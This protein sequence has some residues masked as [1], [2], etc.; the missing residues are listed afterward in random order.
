MLEIGV[1][2]GG[3]SRLFADWLGDDAKIT[4]I[5]IDEACRNSAA[6]DRI[7]IEIG[8]Q[9]DR[10]FLSSLAEKHGPWDII[11]DDGGHT[12]NQM[13]TS[14][15]VLFYHLRDDGI[16]IIEDTHAH[17]FGG[18]YLD[19]PEKKT[20]VDFVAERFVDLHFWTRHENLW[21]H[22]HV[23]PPSRNQVLEAPYL[24]GHLRA[25][26]LYDSIVVIEKGP[27]PEPFS[28]MRVAHRPR[29]TTFRFEE[30]DPET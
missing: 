20:I 5:D 27:R 16:Y 12:S 17:F 4:G 30:S 18:K 21:S 29:Q 26:H 24:A 1:L 3:S 23:P 15:E 11:L 8:D 22:W 10:T 2:H 13:F 25:I 28:E 6:P 19:H 7:A 14:F 9:A